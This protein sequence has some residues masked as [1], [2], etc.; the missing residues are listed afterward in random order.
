[1]LGTFLKGFNTNEMAGGLT[2]AQI[3]HPIRSD[4]TV[5][6]IAVGLTTVSGGMNP[7]ARASSR[8]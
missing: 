8:A 1:M 2:Q 3:N 7:F 5:P 6:A 4:F